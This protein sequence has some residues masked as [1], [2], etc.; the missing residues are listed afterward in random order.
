MRGGKSVHW[1]LPEYVDVSSWI[2]V[3][4]AEWQ[5]A[6]PVRFPQ[7]SDWHTRPQWTTIAEQWAAASIAT[8]E[9]EEAAAFQRLYKQRHELQAQLELEV[10]RASSS[11]RSILTTQGDEL[12]A[13]VAKFLGALGFIV[14][15]MDREWNQGDRREDLR[16]QHE[17]AP[18]WEAIV[19]VRGYTGGAQLR[20][21]QRIIRF[22]ARYERDHSRRPDAAWYVVN[23]FAGDDP[24]FRARPL[25]SNP[26]EVEDFSLSDNGLVVDTRD[27]FGLCAAVQRD[28]IERDEAA[29]S[30][31]TG[32]GDF[33]RPD[34]S[35]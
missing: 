21:L 33:S 6:D 31:I 2:R 15:E 20:D 4:F 23:Q 27:L 18:G 35:V 26:L 25:A 34:K 32:R 24:D 16:L 5:A 28:D 8:F 13:A 12:V 19:E 22:C 1:V 17:V 30:L 10:S 9:A 3:A 7:V 14:H 29:R 11:E